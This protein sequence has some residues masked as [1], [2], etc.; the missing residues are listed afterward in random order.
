MSIGLGGSE[1]EKCCNCG[2]NCNCHKKPDLKDSW[3][4]SIGGPSD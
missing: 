1:E 2:C 4:E 3:D